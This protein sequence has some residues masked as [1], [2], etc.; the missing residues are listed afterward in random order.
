MPVTTLLSCIVYDILG[1]R[2]G[3][4]VATGIGGGSVD[5]SFT[6]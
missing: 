5:E 6:T 2:G 3:R 1:K 4:A